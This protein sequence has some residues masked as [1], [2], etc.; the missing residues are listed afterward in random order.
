MIKKAL[1]LLTSAMF[2]SACSTLSSD[3]WWHTDLPVETSKK[4]NGAYRHA[5]VTQRTDNKA[6]VSRNSSVTRKQTITANIVREGQI[7][8]S[9][10]RLLT[11]EGDNANLY[12]QIALGR[13]PGN[14]DATLGI[15]AIVDKYLAWA[16]QSANAADFK[17]AKQFIEQAK[18]VNPRDPSIQEIETRVKQKWVVI[19]HTVRADQQPAS[20]DVFYLP[21]NLFQLSEEKI[22]TQIQPIIDRVEKTQGS[23]EIN[24]PSDKEGRLL[25][26]IINSRTPN[27]RVR[28]MTFHS[29]KHTVEVLVN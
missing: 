23:I 17:S 9:E 19:D 12:F 15:A 14:Y 27:F 18:Q 1:F 8:L 5:P 26:Q 20:E 3:N 16:I 29:S 25:Y 4:Q 2:L 11:P 13:D 10:N 7:A 24:W 21:N 28:A 22:L 6:G